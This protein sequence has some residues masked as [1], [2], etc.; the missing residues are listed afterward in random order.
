MKLSLAK[1]QFTSIA[2]IIILVVA[3]C[4]AP[5]LPTAPEAQSS[6]EPAA[7]EAIGA[8]GSESTSAAETSGANATFTILPDQSQAR[9]YIDEV[10]RGD[11]IT[12]VGTSSALSG[13]ITVDPVNL[14][15][16]QVGAI[17]IDAGSFVTDSDRRNGAIRRFVLSASS[18]PTITFLPTSIQNLPDSAAPGDVLE[19]Q[20]V[21][22]LTLKDQTRSETFD[23]SVSIDSETQISGLASTTITHADYDIFI[24][25]VPFVAN[26]GDQLKLEFEFVAER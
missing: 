13:E 3:A 15:A 17:T 12:V 8:S 10:L 9:F 18:Y 21:G 19:F 22:D 14:A 26:V 23:V 5:A 7:Q 6:T 1:L 16:T 4:S 2:L 11:P 20:V 24:P 25:S